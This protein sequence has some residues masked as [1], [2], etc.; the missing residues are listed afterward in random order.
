MSSLDSTSTL[1]EIRAAY[2]DNGSYY[3]D[4]DR[5]KARAFVTACRLLLLKLPKRSELS[6][7]ELELEPRIIQE[8]MQAAQQW[9][10]SHP[11]ELVG[12]GLVF[13]SFESFRD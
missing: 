2:L 6:D 7:S 11:D 3:E 10:A 8:E 13:A 4:A 9:L 1:A 12:G 5:T